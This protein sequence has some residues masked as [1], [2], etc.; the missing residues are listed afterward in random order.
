MYMGFGGGKKGLFGKVIDPTRSPY[1]TPGIGDGMTVQHT[2]EQR[3]S[4]QPTQGKPSLFGKGGTGRAI[5]GTI[6]DF[7][8]QRSGM[9]PVYAPT[10]QREQQAAA[11]AA[12][13]ELRR[14]QELADFETK[15]GIKARYKTNDT[16]EDFNW[17]QGLSDADKR[18]YHQMRP[19]M[20]QIDN[21]D[22]TKTIVPYN[23]YGMTGA[24]PQGQLPTF[25][26][27]DWEAAGSNAGGNFRR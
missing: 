11:Q 27:E 14:A 10:M 16:I 26:D 6:G 5:A 17:Y 23:P 20:V 3:Q 2:P 15:E 9:A 8:L 18:A 7:L 12:A 21:G 22:G 24:A 19:Q 4:A 1:E 13:A 25:T